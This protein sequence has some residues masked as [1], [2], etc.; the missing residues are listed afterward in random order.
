MARTGQ[1][2]GV[3]PMGTGSVVFDGACPS[4]DEDRHH[5][6]A[7]GRVSVPRAPNKNFGDELDGR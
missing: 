2:E 4:W 6:R 7:R 5:A 1:D 3:H